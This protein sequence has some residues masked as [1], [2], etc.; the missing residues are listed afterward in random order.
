MTAEEAMIIALRIQS[1]SEQEAAKIILTLHKDAYLEGLNKG[2]EIAQE[3]FKK[4]KKA[5]Y[6]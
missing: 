6:P 3:T 2:D 5:L 1:E 4:I